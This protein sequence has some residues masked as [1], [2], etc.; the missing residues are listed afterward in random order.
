MMDVQLEF[1]GLRGLEFYRFCGKNKE[2]DNKKGTHKFQDSS[3]AHRIGSK[4]ANDAQNSLLLICL[5]ESLIAFSVARG[6]P[7]LACELTPTSPLCQVLIQ[8]ASYL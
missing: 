7:D 6:Q 4:L 1:L 3:F 8:A 5:S 2:K